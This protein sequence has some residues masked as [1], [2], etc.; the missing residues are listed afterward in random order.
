[1]KRRKGRNW[2]P[3]YLDWT[4]MGCVPRLKRQGYAMWKNLRTSD[5]PPNLEALSNSPSL[6]DDAPTNVIW[7]AVPDAIWLGMSVVQGFRPTVLISAVPVVER[8]SWNPNLARVRPTDKV[9]CSTSS[10]I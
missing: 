7:N 10:M 2:R 6:L 3:A 5:I 9:D 1:M 4:F 8:R